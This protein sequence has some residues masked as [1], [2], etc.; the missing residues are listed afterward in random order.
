MSTIK[1]PGNCFQ[2]DKTGQ[3]T[4][5][6][7]LREVVPNSGRM[8]CETPGCK[9]GHIDQHKKEHWVGGE[10]VF[11]TKPVEVPEVKET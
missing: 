10:V 1:C 7:T 5:V 8:F 2:K 3:Y 6:G 4:I 11:W 9:F